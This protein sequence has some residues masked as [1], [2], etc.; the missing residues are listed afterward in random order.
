[1]LG[2]MLVTT[3]MRGEDLLLASSQQGPGTL[4]KFLQSQSSPP[5]AGIIQSKMSIVLLLRYAAINQHEKRSTI[6]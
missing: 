2:D 4:L 3:E 5:E 1:M 6:Q